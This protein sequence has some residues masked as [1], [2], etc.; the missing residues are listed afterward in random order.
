VLAIKIGPVLAVYLYVIGSGGERL[1][2]VLDGLGQHDCLGASGLDLNH[3]WTGS[4]V[5]PNMLGVAQC[6]LGK[7]LACGMDLQGVSSGEGCCWR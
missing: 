5:A 2:V 7:A 1:T 3:F 6:V 4:Q